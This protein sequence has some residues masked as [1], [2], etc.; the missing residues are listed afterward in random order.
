MR[1]VVMTWL[2]VVTTA[3]AAPVERLEARPADGRIVVN[4]YKKGAFSAFAH[5]H[6]FDVKEWR[7]GAELS[8]GDP[9]SVSLDV[10][11][12]AASLRDTQQR[13]SEAD[14]KKVDAQAAGPEVLDAAHHPRI[15]FRSERVE[16]TP[17]TGAGSTARGTL[18]GTLTR[19]GRSVPTDVPFEAERARDGWHVRGTA[20]VKQ[21]DFGIKPFSGFAGTVGVK[22]ELSIEIA[23]TLRPRAE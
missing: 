17:A 20:R 13:L 19:R 7:A 16:L 14:R 23:I 11:I 8:G 18:H 15:A 2:A 4:V 5:D 10:V 12:S 1:F 9:S 21:S 3:A 6:H 22:D